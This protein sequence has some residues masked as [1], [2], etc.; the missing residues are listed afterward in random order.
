MDKYQL[1]YSYRDDFINAMERISTEKVDIFLGNHMQ[2]N[3][4]PKKYNEL[5]NGNTKA[6]IGTSE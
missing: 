2:Q 1:P 4:S 5:L 3:D 6:F